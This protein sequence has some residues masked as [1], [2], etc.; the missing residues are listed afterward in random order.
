MDD[1]GNVNSSSSMLGALLRAWSTTVRKGASEPR[2]PK[3]ITLDYDG[4]LY[5][6][7][8]AYSNSCQVQDR[9]KGSPGIKPCPVLDSAAGIWQTRPWQ[10]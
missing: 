8:G 6:N 4:N 3:A 2:K 7:I 10:T 9:T 5:V 1:R